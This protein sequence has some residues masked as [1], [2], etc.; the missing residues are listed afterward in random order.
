LRAKRWVVLVA[1][2]AVAAADAPVSA[3]VTGAGVELR[4]PDGARLRIRA[5]SVVD[6][7]RDHS[8]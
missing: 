4:H 2:G 7:R 8:G 5:G 1:A 3:T 6:P